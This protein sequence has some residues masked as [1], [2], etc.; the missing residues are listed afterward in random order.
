FTNNFAYGTL[1]LG[2]SAYVRLVDNA[3]NSAGTGSEALY[4]NGLIVPSG[5]TLDLHGLH[6]YAR[7]SQILGQVINGSV[8]YTPDGGPVIL[9]KAT[10]GALNVAGQVDDWTFFGRAGQAVTV[11]VG[12]G[13]ASIPAPLTP[14]VGYA[15]V[16]LLDPNGNSLGTSSN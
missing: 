15:Q 6:V 1:A 7:G 10:S 11:V 14:A 9:N 5:T 13:S 12:T 16:T 8:S 2:G 3:D 4:I